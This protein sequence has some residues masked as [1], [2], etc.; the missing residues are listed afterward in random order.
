MSQNNYYKAFSFLV[1]RCA[2]LFILCVIFNGPSFAAQD[3]A[4]VSIQVRNI[5]IAK[6]FKVLKQQTGF[7]VFYDN[8]IIDDQQKMDV[9]LPH[10]SVTGLM[11]LITKGRNLTF[12]IKDQFI[13]LKP[14]APVSALIDADAGE[15]THDA[16]AGLQQDFPV[17]GVVRGPAGEGL[18]GVSVTL[19]GTKIGTTTDAKGAFSLTLPNDNGTLVFSYVGFE[20][21]EVRINHRSGMMTISLAVANASLNQI[22]VTALGLKQ[23]KKA[24]TYAT[25]SVNTD[26]LSEAMEL[27]ATNSLEGKVAGL[28]I[29]QSGGGVGAPSRVV[30]R[31]NR[32]ISGDSQPLYV[33]DGVPTLGY[34]ENLDPDNFESI[35][36]L[37]GANAA[38]LYG[39]DAQNGAIIITTKRGKADK[40]NISFNNNFML[41]QADIGLNFQNVYGQGLS[42]VFASG[43]GYSWGPQMTGQTVANW[44]LNP[45]RAGETYAMYPQPNNVNH[46]F[47]N[48]YTIS[49]N[50]QLST[51]NA[52]SQTFFS[53]TST[54]GSGTLPQNTLLR[55]NFLLRLNNKLTDKLSLDAK[56][57]YTIQNTNNPT[58]QSTN[59]YNPVFQ[60][61]NMPRN[62]RTSDAKQFEYLNANGI[63]AQDFWAPGAVST[64][65]NPYWV[66]NRNLLYDKL[67]RMTG[68]VSLSYDFTKDLS[69][70]VR[71]SYDRLDDNQQ[72]K[73][74]YGTL[75]RAPQGMFSVSSFY[76]YD[77][78]T[79]FL[80]SYSK[81]LNED[82]KFDVHAGGNLKKFNSDSLVTST[83][84]AMLIP[85]F[86]SLSNTNLPATS[87]S[88]GAPE[89]IQSLYA[90]GNINW[91]EEVY[92]DVTGRNDWSSTLPASSRSYFYPS[93]GT[94]VILSKLIPDMPRAISF[95]K[96]RASYAKVGSSPPPFRTERT[97]SFSSGGNNG[98]LSLSS[99]LPNTTLK[100]EETKSE[101]GGLNVGFLNGRI[102]VDFT[103]YVTNTENQLFTI[104]L[105][106]GSGASSYF[107]NGGDVR[108]RGEEVILNTVPI[109]TKSFTWDLDINFSHVKNTVVKISDQRPQIIVGS[110]SY[111]ANYVIQQGQNFG[112]MYTFGLKRD[113]L[114]R[115]IVGTNGVP[116]V[117]SSQSFNIGTYTPQWT[118]GIANT[119]TYKN[120]SMSVLIEHRQGGVVEDYTDAYLDYAGLTKETLTGRQ[121]GLVFGGNFMPKYKTVTTT[122]E[123][124]NTAVNAQT[125]WSAMANPSIP[126]GELFARSATYTRV[127]EVTFGYTLPHS[128][129]EKMHIANMKVSLVGRNLFFISRATPGLDPDILTG[130]TTA[131]EGFS[132]FAPPTTRSYGINLKVELK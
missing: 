16:S 39:S 81:A 102:G 20:S 57:N 75:V 95:L 26:A 34:P 129:C 87:F 108:N 56:M 79:D 85:N 88:S 82:W 19:K 97:A 42:G 31:G 91:R 52:K 112:N 104:A 127:R 7:V 33:I 25:Q 45:A 116:Q 74:Y 65:E 35:N 76:N 119:F 92:L 23:Q 120:F 64:S 47:H 107:T 12:V 22:V 70:M 15:G 72:E 46:F 37:K 5:S 14:K 38:A 118:G 1:R 117:T 40:V 41:Q 55:E 132:S 44:T 18:T 66:L 96:V 90:F 111:I 80:L 28:S 86:F 122:G 128:T 49:N 43:D 69:L 27:N 68:M 54:E 115:V 100:P 130:T 4:Y 89:N 11:N 48:G 9:D 8:K 36:V 99:V 71:G 63:M 83:G 126:I 67:N 101:E 51:G 125:F 17:T 121:G 2:A 29:S 62:I 53:A 94:S 105:P 131:L 58:R 59:N 93:I 3:S 114:G 106:V 77:L 110:D 13:V 61:Y 124:N 73:D 30:L 60:V 109:R 32:S 98:F 84:V 123:T 50:V 113:S 103:Y 10:S 78:N 6:L 24:L 21:Q